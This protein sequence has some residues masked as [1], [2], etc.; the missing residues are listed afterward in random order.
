MRNFCVFVFGKVVETNVKK[1]YF[2]KIY[3]KS[4]QFTC[5]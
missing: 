3:P 2:I 1:N 5:E 4:G